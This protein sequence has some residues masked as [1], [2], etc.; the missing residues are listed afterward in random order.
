MQNDNKPSPRPSPGWLFACLIASGLLAGCAD[1]VRERVL[2]PAR[3]LLQTAQ[4]LIQALPTAYYLENLVDVGLLLGAGPVQIPLQ[5][6]I[7][8]L[9]I[10]A[11]ILAVGLTSE[12]RMDAPKGPIGDAVW[13]SAFWYRGGGNPGAIGTATIA[14]HVNDPL[15]VPE[16]FANLAQLQPG[17][18]IIIHAKETGLDIVFV[19]YE[20]I[21]YTTLESL[22]PAILVR[23]FG[24]GPVTGK[25]AQPAQDGLSHL[26]LITCAGDIID[27]AFDHHTVVYATRSD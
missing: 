1:D 25:A 8:A 17:D 27:G 10:S 21:T 23:I 19:I 7:P 16:I 3:V 18:Q 15:G 22:D 24:A 6:V 20:V 2:P 14:A 5:L 12:N 13:G 26:A 11:P 9:G 4:P